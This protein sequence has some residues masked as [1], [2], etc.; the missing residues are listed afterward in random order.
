MQ[1]IRY[2]TR[3][4]EDPNNRTTANKY[5]FVAAEILSNSAKLAD[6]FIEELK[7]EFPTTSVNLSSSP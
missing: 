4:P 1:L 5:P 7:Q 6:A 3:I 2:A